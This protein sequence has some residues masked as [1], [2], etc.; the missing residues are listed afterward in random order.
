MECFTCHDPHQ[1]DSQLKQKGKGTNVEGNAD[2]SFLRN[3][4]LQQPVLCGKCHQR[5]SLVVGTDHDMRVVAPASI[6]LSGKP[7]KE[8]SVC[9]PCHA[10]HNAA[11]ETIL[12]N[13]P[14]AEGGQDFMEK[15]CIGCHS[16]TGAG[17]DKI[18]T[19]GIHPKQ[20]YF[21]YHK[22]Y[23]NILLSIGPTPDPIPLYAKDGKKS[24]TGEITCATCHDPH[25]WFSTDESYRAGQEH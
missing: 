4:N 1:W 18:V 17:K 15:A 6:G 2:T 11:Q 21:G 13:S 16:T 22:S 23:R 7:A 14:L 12:W 8:E 25:I 5:K 9:A 3:A 24:P 19:S 20:F 10:V